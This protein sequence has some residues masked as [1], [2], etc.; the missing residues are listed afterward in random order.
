M[1]DIFEIQEQVG[2]QIAESLK[3]KLSMTEKIALTKRPTVNAQAYDLYLRGKEYLYRRTKRH[4]EYA[5][6]LFEKAIELD[7]RFAAAYAGCSSAYGQLFA[8]FQRED[9]YKDK[10]Q[11]LSFKA[12]MYDNNLP[13]AYAA[14]GLSY[15]LWNRFDEAEASSKKAIELDP[16]DFIAVW[17]LGR[18]YF[19]H[20]DFLHAV[21]LFRKVIELKSGFYAAYNDLK[22]TYRALGQEEE[23]ITMLQKLLEVLPNYL[24]QSPDDAR[25]RMFYAGVLAEDGRVDVAKAEG[26][27]AIELSPGD[28]LMMYNASCLYAQLGEIKLSIKTLQD[29]IA[30]GHEEFEWIKRDSDLDPIRS[31]PEYIELMKDK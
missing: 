6:Q 12:L 20:G 17:T 26:A 23:A 29:A 3:L 2:Q 4:I 8:S 27:A 30:A 18:I 21:P 1:D 16:D 14:M 5:I 22:L 10:A 19:S 9:K 13:E 28:A 7:P 31:D 15:L 25:A 24:L 11:E